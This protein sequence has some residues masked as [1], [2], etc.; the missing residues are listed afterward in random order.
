LEL[1]FIIQVATG[2]GG[3]IGA[4]FAVRKFYKW[5][6][7]IKISPGYFISMDG[8]QSDAIVA[9]I[10]NSS[11]ENLYVTECTARG[12]FSLWH[13]IKTHIKNP[14]VKPHLYKNIRYNGVVYSLSDEAS[15]KLEAG[16]PTELKH[17]LSEHFLSTMHTPYFVVFVKLSSGRTIRSHK[18]CTPASWQ[19]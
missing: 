12:T 7:P 5:L 2:I 11:P 4:I 13:I 8:S 18:V 14:L 6:F 3:L 1:E 16:Q 10:T 19:K 9:K 15:V 17:E